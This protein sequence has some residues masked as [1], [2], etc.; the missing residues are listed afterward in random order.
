MAGPPP[1]Q[2]GVS[3]QGDARA[4]GM[5][6]G[7]GWPPGWPPGFY[8]P[9]YGVPPGYYPPPQPPSDGRYAVGQQRPGT[10]FPQP[11]Q[12][13]VSPSG[14]D[15]RSRGEDPAELKE[16]RARASE[17][18]RENA[19][20]RASLSQMP[21]AEQSDKD[22]AK[23]HAQELARLKQKHIEELDVRAK[24]YS[25]QLAQ[26]RRKAGVDG[27][28]VERMEE[29]IRKLDRRV[30]ELECELDAA[31]TNQIEGNTVM[32]QT[33]EDQEIRNMKSDAELLRREVLSTRAQ[34][35][36][37]GSRARQLEGALRVFREVSRDNAAD[38]F[39]EAA[40]LHHESV[41]ASHGAVTDYLSAAWSSLQSASAQRQ[42]QQ[43][44]R[45]KQQITGPKCYGVRQ[46]PP[47]PP[48][49]PAAGGGRPPPPPYTVLLDLDGTLINSFYDTPRQQ[50]QYGDVYSVDVRAGMRVCLEQLVRHK[51]RIEVGIFT[52]SQ[53]L[54]CEGIR[55]L[56]SE[57][58]CGMDQDPFDFAVANSSDDPLAQERIGTTKDLAILDRER[59][60]VLL[61]DN[62]PGVVHHSFRTSTI[63]T[64]D[65]RYDPKGRDST[66]I[67]VAE[68]VTRL[69]ETG[70][71][72]P[73][74][75]ETEARRDPKK[76][77]ERTRK[78]L[79]QA[80]GYYFVARYCDECHKMEGLHP[81]QSRSLEF[82]LDTDSWGSYC[83]D[84]WL[85]RPANARREPR[86]WKGSRRGGRAP[87][88]LRPLSSWQQSA[89]HLTQRGRPG[90]AEEAAPAAVAAP[91]AS[92]KSRKA[93]HA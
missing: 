17:L 10:G 81:D 88:A 16:L 71:S 84:C 28:E 72:V 3:Q 15:F 20:L 79:Y 47:K 64:P 70:V 61:V 44:P 39:E 41:L 42:Q 32:V 67:A 66:L 23:Q 45:G 51:P 82:L 9:P 52:A 48:R 50:H 29:Q 74:F 33:D 83:K 78:L 89:P 91:K 68:L 27:S 57:M 37:E 30:R 40:R 75:L 60:R 56:I 76:D 73:T 59:S 19:S 80:G 77:D 25:R 4:N 2:P 6:P 18:S 90:L 11:T 7:M 63:I 55:K 69:V 53:P 58:V 22:V 36:E 5:H 38:S 35:E 85:K 43:Q 26:V 92:P 93:G 54:Y 24:E 12:P 21:R 49:L 14:P 1:M 34:V 86:N 87:L 8:P 31:R 46:P 13:Q 62:D 65:F